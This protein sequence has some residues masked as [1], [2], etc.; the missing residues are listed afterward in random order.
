MERRKESFHNKQTRGL[1]KDRQQKQMKTV[2]INY[3][4]IELVV[5]NR[6]DIWYKGRKLP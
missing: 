5:G 1:S 3:K 4:G 6:G 2:K